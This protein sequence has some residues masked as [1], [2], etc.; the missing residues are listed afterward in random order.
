MHSIILCIL[1]CATIH[2]MSLPCQ[3][4]LNKEIDLAFLSAKYIYIVQV[5]NDKR[6][7]LLTNIFVTSLYV[8]LNSFCHLSFA[9]NPTVVKEDSLLRKE[10]DWNI[11]LRVIS[12][13]PRNFQ[14]KFKHPSINLGDAR[15]DFIFEFQERLPPL[16]K[17]AWKMFA[18]DWLGI[19]G[20]KKFCVR[21]IALYI[22]H[23]KLRESSTKR[24]TIWSVSGFR[25]S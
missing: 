7:V 22:A 20:N 13:M 12:F 11:R 1:Y 19:S 2:K 4:N 17:F 8:Q 25:C 23:I 5:C 21:A 10:L 16:L 9:W 24:I 6:C 18:D 14:S 3:I 15:N